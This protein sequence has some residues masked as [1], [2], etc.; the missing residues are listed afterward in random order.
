MRRR[1]NGNFNAASH[2]CG[3][4]PVARNG[5]HYGVGCNSVFDLVPNNAFSN[6]P[7]HDT[8]SVE[9]GHEQLKSKNG[10]RARRN[11]DP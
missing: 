5:F 11:E 6:W 1:S 8:G 2:R 4:G 9:S 3:V 7:C 10:P